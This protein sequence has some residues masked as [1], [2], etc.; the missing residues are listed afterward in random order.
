MEGSNTIGMFD[1]LV[2]EYPLGNEEI[3]NLSYQTK[4]LENCLFKYKIGVDARLYLNK[5]EGNWEPYTPEEI[6]AMD[7][8]GLMTK[9]YVERG[10]YNKTSDD[11]MLVEDFSGDIDFYASVKRPKNDEC[12]VEFRAYFACGHMQKL[13]ATMLPVDVEVNIAPL[14]SNTVID[15]RCN[16]ERVYSSNIPMRTELKTNEDILVALEAMA[17]ELRAK[18]QLTK[19]AAVE[20]ETIA[21][22]NE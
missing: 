6:A 11:W 1:D 19:E 7:P 9:W 21:K 13:V 20:V 16:G 2:C 5:I 8:N 15:V 17:S 18:I 10:K 3:Q 4:D 14:P 12:W 22:E